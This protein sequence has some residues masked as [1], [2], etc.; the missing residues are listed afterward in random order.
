MQ[1]G[2]DIG[3]TFTDIVALD[4]TGRLSLT[5]VPSTPKD[6]LEGIGAAVSQVLALAGAPSSA[7]ERFIHGTTVAT[8]AILEQKGA[9]TAVLTTEGFEDVL[10]LGR[11]KRSR[12]YDLS[13]DAEVP[14]F[15]AP[16]RRRLGIRERL[17][18]RGH[19]LV[20]LD[21]DA[22]RRAVGALRAQA[23]QAVAVC[24]LF[25][26]VN[27]A[28]ERRTREILA[29]LAPELSVSLSS[30][31]D[32]T[33][34][35]YER[36]CVTAFDA[37]LGPVVKRYLAGLADTLGRLGVPGVP[38]IMRSRGGIVSA[39]LAAQQPVTLFLSGPAGGVIGAGFAAER[40]GVRDFVSLDMGGTSNDVALV[41]DG[42]PLLAS[43][44]S[45]GPYPV[46]T[47]MV[48]LNTIGAGGGS[49]AWID[50][51]GGLRVGPRSAGADPGPACYGRGGDE[52]TV[53][54][55]SVVL[56]YLNPA[57]FA[58]GAVALDAGAA[59][60][61]VA[62][63]GRRLGVDPVAAA[64]GIHRVVNARM[65][66]QI[67]LVTIK[68]GYDPRQFALVVLG[69]AGPVH[70]AALAE[71]M[72]MAEV[73]V[74]EV[75]GVLAAFGLLAAAIEHHHARTL[76]ARTDAADLGAVNHRLGELDTAGRD[77]MREEGVAADHVRV[78][79]A[80]DMR[81]VGQAYELEVP[82]AV[83]VTREAMPE[84]LAAFHA[85]HERVYGYARAQ[86][87]VEFVNLR[88]VHTF[89]LP[90]P[91]V[92]PAARA[93]GTLDDA[94]LGER[95]AY[96]GGFVPTTVYERAR[97]PLGARLAGPAIV[98]QS[99]TTTVI[100]PGVTAR[101]DDAGSLRLRRA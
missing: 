94:R 31:V 78:T 37:Y 97:L 40:S 71:E 39:A 96:F 33:F 25:S 72:G 50:A 81:Y 7:V 26:F 3:G 55:A 44:G 66:D 76:Q 18:A 84:I 92:T 19:V 99:D 47:P 14:T 85:V 17:D 20:P 32:P 67:R 52:A 101:V 28:H 23:V 36:L 41:R 46:R 54:D 82:I 34:R 77:R 43:E 15:L 13:M 56:G 95:R 27:P 58:G 63:I 65:A 2:V 51:A 88:A 83:P 38:L 100:P 35:E 49:I 91:V 30:D 79:Y 6:L 68:R 42:R 1:I 74:P 10:E 45:I 9:V 89:P 11:M 73:L 53:T 87:P 62:A 59:E 64:A 12:M 86:Q 61:A 29:E 90:R 8:N 5:K 21:E 80:A 4:R 60:R 98:E 69:G 48:D 75:P 57:R 22:V 70:G 93:T 16:R 24:Y